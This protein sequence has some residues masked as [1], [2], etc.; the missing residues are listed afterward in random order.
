M[1]YSWLAVAVAGLHLAFL[2]YL[3][4]GGYLA[5]RWPRTVA[6]HILA[7][8]WA[9][10]VVAASL[11]CPLTSAQNWLR[12]R[13]QEPGLARSFLNTYVRG[14]FYPAD[15]E[16]VV[17]ALVAIVVLAS[18]T[19]LLLRHPRHHD[20]QQSSNRI[21]KGRLGRIEVSVLKECAGDRRTVDRPV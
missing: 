19:G 6:L 18:W 21:P 14:I 2:A 4:T 13:A 20:V 3:V 12:H 15:H 10:V 5:W 7:A 8:S 16:Q 1:L 11:P 17:Q 9:F